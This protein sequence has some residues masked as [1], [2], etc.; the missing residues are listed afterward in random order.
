MSMGVAN[1]LTKILKSLV[2]KSPHHIHS[3][4]DFVEQANNITLMSGEYLSPYDVSALFASV[5]VDPALGII[6]DLLEKDSTLKERTV[7]PVKDI[8]LLLEFCL[9][10][11]YFSFQ[12]QYYEQVEGAAMGCLVGPIVANPYMKYFEQ[13]ALGSATPKIWLRYVDDTWVVQREENNQ[14]FFQ[15]INSVD[16]AIM[17]TVE[18]NKED[19]AIPFLDTI[20]KPEADGKLSITVYREPTNKDQYLQWNSHHHLSAK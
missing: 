18:N 9:K 19:G 7:L 11:T 16:L 5:L 10:N 17:F 6:K 8:I 2:G 20:I 12:G 15:H 13:K 14:S 1:V 3:T 4:R